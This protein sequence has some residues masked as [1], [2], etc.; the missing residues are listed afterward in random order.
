MWREIEYTPIGLYFGG[1]SISYFHRLSIGDMTRSERS[2]D[3]DEDQIRIL[4]SRHI[5]MHTY[6]LKNSSGQ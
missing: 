1:Y 4:T 6:R 2:K 3:D 5:G